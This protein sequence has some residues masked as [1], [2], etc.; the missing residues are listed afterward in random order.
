MKDGYFYESS[1]S[2]CIVCASTLNG[3]RYFT[4]TENS[5]E[6]MEEAEVVEIE[7]QVE[8]NEPQ[9]ETEEPETNTATESPLTE[10]DITVSFS[11]HTHDEG[12][13]EEVSRPSSP[14]KS[15]ENSSSPPKSIPDLVPVST[16]SV[17]VE[18]R[19]SEDVEKTAESAPQVLI[20]V[21]CH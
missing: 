1:E 19:S 2:D 4:A 3:M 13:Q 14:E 21:L 12:T 6:A 16:A 18:A 9:V 7:T 5:P 8:A 15:K 10:Q 20:V 11:I 17:I